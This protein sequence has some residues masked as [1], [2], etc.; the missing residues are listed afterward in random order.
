MQVR[1]LTATSQ[2]SLCHVRDLDTGLRA[3]RIVLEAV[4][5]GGHQLGHR[6]Q[7][8]VDVGD[9]DVREIRRAA[10]GVLM[11]SARGR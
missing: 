3:Y 6:G 2:P 8:P 10:L 11:R 5:D 1:R 7:V 4:R 9:L